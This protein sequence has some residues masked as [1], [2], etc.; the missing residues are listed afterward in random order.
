MRANVHITVKLPTDRDSLIEQLAKL[1]I[2]RSTDAESPV[3][4]HDELRTIPSDQSTELFVTNDYGIDAIRQAKY[5][6]H[7]I[8]KAGGE[9]LVG[10]KTVTMK[11]DK[12]GLVT[13]NSSFGDQLKRLIEAQKL[14]TDV[15]I[16]DEIT[17]SAKMHDE[18]EDRVL[19]APTTR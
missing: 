9:A 13:D 8:Q 17:L 16:V 14:N 10:E 15:L 4:T 5:A 7:L 3:L 19:A 2:R 6:A 1:N 18:T 11:A 12:P